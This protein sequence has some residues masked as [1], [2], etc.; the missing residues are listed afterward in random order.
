MS[1]SM[2]TKT[3]RSGGPGGSAPQTS[4]DDFLGGR[5]TVSQPKEGHRAGSDTVW[6][7][8]AVPAREGSRVLDAG[9]G[10]GV[11]GLCLAA[12][13]PRLH[14]TAVEIDAGLCGLAEANAAR[15]GLAARFKVVNADVTSP[16]EALVAKGLKREGYDQV[17]ANPPYYRERTVRPGPDQARAAAHVMQEGALA[18]W[19]R[20]LTT[21]AAPKGLLTLVHQPQALPELLPLLDRRIRRHDRLSAVPESRP[22]RHTHHRPG[23]ERK[24]RRGFASARSRAARGGWRLHG[25]G[26]SGLEDRRG[27]GALANSGK[28]KGCRLGVRQQPSIGPSVRVAR[29]SQGRLVADLVVAIDGLKD[30]FAGIVVPN[31][32]GHGT[33]LG[34]A[35]RLIVG[36]VIAVAVTVIV[37]VAK[38]IT[39]GLSLRSA[40]R[41]SGKGRR[42]SGSARTS[43]STSS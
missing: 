6:L 25:K 30:V 16:A 18:A 17:M 14:V 20:F 4:L 12:R 40:E 15:N 28:T 1:L 21:M 29:G 33:G 23:A 19:V 37:A 8:A 26:R 27:P 22:A 34:V 39:M 10:V 43:G 2:K 24:P 42:R 11:A 9:A 35:A 38:A 31:L 7:Q 36:V 5:I 3:E 13:F 32:D 41:K